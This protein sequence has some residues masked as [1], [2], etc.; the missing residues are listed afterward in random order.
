MKKHYSLLLAFMVAFSSFFVSCNEN[1]NG[2]DSTICKIT[3]IS[4]GDGDGAV[5]ITNYIGTSVNVLIGNQ[6]EVVAAPAEGSAFI[7]WYMGNSNTPVSTEK[8]L[9]FTAS[10]NTTLIARF[11]KLSNLTLCSSAYGSVSIKDV[12]GT[13]N[14]FL[15]GC[16]VIVVATP[17]EDC[18]FIG[19]FIDDA[20]TPVSTD[21]EYT[22]IVEENI[23]LTAKFSKRPIVTVRS[24]GNGSV[25]IKD[26]YGT[27]NAF[28]PG[29]EVIVVATPDEG[30][31]FSGWFV[32]DDEAPVSTA[33]E[34]TFAVSVDVELT[35]KFEVNYNG[36]EYVDLG[37]PSGIKWA[38]CN[39]GATKPG[40]YGDYYAW[41]E[42][43]EKYEY[44]LITY[45]WCNGSYTPMTKY[46]TVDNKTV[47]DP[48]DDVAHVEWGGSWRMPTLDEQIELL[49]KCTW[50]WT[51]Q[52]GRDGYEVTGPNG[53]SIFLPAAGYRYGLYGAGT[54]LH[55]SGSNGYYWSSSLSESYS[56]ARYLHIDGDLNSFGHLISEYRYY[57]LSV[58]PVSK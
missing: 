27:S 36:H 24:A 26:V 11:A 45:K 5:S 28:L 13:S 25:S 18:D 32:G 12:Y 39:V 1:E 52:N 41:G 47:L 23:T 6:V 8:K 35:A 44:S 57:G 16:E 3:V 58:R 21:A 40:E 56:F 19:W 10:E 49:N 7:G 17:D 20:E 33:A 50:T 15:P 37:L 38:T 54:T 14:A 30:Y 9:V 22:F 31:M 2:S 55:N 46:C 51:T 48:E 53:N 29:S 4:D 42:T 43:H 34:Y